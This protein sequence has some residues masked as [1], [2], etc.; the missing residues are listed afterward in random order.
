[1]ME[2]RGLNYDTVKVQTSMSDAMPSMMVSLERLE[3]KIQRLL[4]LQDEILAGI[5]DLP[6]KRYGKILTYRY[7][8][9]MTWD[10]IADSLDISPRW[11][12][13]L[14]QRAELRYYKGGN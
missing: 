8:V 4:R 9:G 14:C 1:M 12:R 6:N 13:R 7:V 5:N 3:D 10:E 11:A 2:V